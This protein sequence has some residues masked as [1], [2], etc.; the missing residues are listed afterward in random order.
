ME[1]NTIR[2]DFSTLQLSP[3][4]SLRIEEGLPRL[5]L[6]RLPDNEEIE[7]KGWLKIE[8]A[9]G[10]FLSWGFVDTSNNAVHLI[11]DSENDP[12]VGLV[13]RFGMALKKR[14]EMKALVGEVVRLV[15]SAGDNLSGFTL[16]AYGKTVI[17]SLE[18]KALQR[19]VDNLL[20]EVL[21][22]LQPEQII[23]KIREKR[24]QLKG[25]ISQKILLGKGLIDKIWVKES[26]LSYLVQPLGKL[27]TGLFF[28]L[29]Y[30]RKEFAKGTK[31]CGVLNLFSYTGAFSLAA[32]NAG[33]RRVVSIEIDSVNQNW[34]QQNFRKNGI[35]AKDPK[36]L[37]VKD[38]VFHYIDKLVSRS[39]V[40]ER[41]ILD[42]PSR[43]QVGSG[44]FFLKTDLPKLV[45]S[46]LNLLTPKG[47]L[48][49]TDNTMLG[50]S[51][52]LE[53]RIKKGAE[54]ANVK[55]SI[56]K[57]FKPEPDFPVNPLWPKGRGVIAMEVE[58]N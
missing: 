46:C 24:P 1:L 58:R 38:D 41:I 28:D 51:E 31:D 18:C 5:I 57:R 56:V 52:K 15:N 2:L 50:T 37:F 20:E 33:A 4:L 25:K 8:D 44:R 48:L 3:P 54:I 30:A 35:D 17:L 6:D 29:R 7:S 32:A 13:A 55:C 10:K 19:L 42:P 39:E 14:A 53:Q 27:D 43:L 16:D 26:G 45:A 22:P 34:A 11:S 9:D 12:L 36:Y 49:I 40:F 23:L 21:W 47:R